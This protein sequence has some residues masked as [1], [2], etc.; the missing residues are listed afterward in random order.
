LEYEFVVDRSP[1][2]G[3]RDCGLLFLNPEPGREASEESAR[4]SKPSTSIDV[5]EAKAAERI[6]ELTSYSGLT[7]GT[8][9]LVGATA[10][11]GAE[12]RKAGFHI[13]AFS[14]V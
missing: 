5:Y 1:V 6:Q 4:S 2:C 10:H 7:D 11:L 9:L 14:R 13:H 12:A 3:C 8:L